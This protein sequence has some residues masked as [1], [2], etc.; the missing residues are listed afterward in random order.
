MIVDNVTEPWSVGVIVVE[1]VIALSSGWA[2]Q[3]PIRTVHLPNPRVVPEWGRGQVVTI[4]SRLTAAPQPHHRHHPRVHQPASG[5]ASEAKAATEP[6][7]AAAPRG[8]KH[9]VR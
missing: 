9:V 3:H 8:R 2:A 4:S 6:N 1:A 7:L 5:G